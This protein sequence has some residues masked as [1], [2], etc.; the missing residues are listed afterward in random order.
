M[1]DMSMSLRRPRQCRPLVALLAVAV[2]LGSLGGCGLPGVAAGSGNAT[3]SELRQLGAPPPFDARTAK[4]SSS[5]DPSCFSDCPSVTIE[6]EGPADLGE[7]QALRLVGQFLTDAGYFER[8]PSIS[9]W[10]CQWIVVEDL[11]EPHP[12]EPPERECLVTTTLG[13]DERSFSATL[14][15]IG[16]SQSDDHA[17][18]LKLDF[19]I[20][21]RD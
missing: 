6:Y 16:K 21:E 8:G 10:G 3:E 20:Q 5:G 9:E 11:P 18:M 2:I 7:E 14:V 15:W 1:F 13:D 17:D 4:V 12:E 19:T